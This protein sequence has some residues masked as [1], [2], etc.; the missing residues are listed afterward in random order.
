[1]SFDWADYL[2]LAEELA[3][4]PNDMPNKEAATRAAISRAYYAAFKKA[5]EF[6]VRRDGFV[7]NLGPKKTYNQQDTNEEDKNKGS[8]HVRVIRQ[9]T[10]DKYNNNRMRIGIA[11]TRMKHN[12]ESAD[13]DAEFMGN[14]EEALKDTLIKA[15]DVI[16]RLRQLV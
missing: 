2:S 7:V 9:F 4:K 3:Q 8:S 1:M 11:L 14:I 15:K 12:R 6:V 16:S 13:Y 5:E 10:K